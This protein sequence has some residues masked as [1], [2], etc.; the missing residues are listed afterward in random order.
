M[1]FC[2]ICYLWVVGL[3]GCLVWVVYSVNGICLMVIDFDEVFFGCDVMVEIFNWIVLGGLV[4]G[5]RVNLECLV[6]VGD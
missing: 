6:L 3:F 4:L 1:G 5:S 2:L